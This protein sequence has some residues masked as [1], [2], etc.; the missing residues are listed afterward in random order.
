V[1]PDHETNQLPTTCTDC[2]TQNTWAPSTF[3]H[4][5]FYPLLGAHATIANQCTQCHING[6][7]STTPNT[8][9]GCHQADYNNTTNP[10]HQTQQFPSDCTDCHSQDAWIPSS[11]N[12]SSFYPLTGAHALI[13]D[14]CIMCHTSGNYNTTPS[15]CVGCHQ[16]DF[17]TASNP[18]HISL[19]FATDCVS[20]H[21][22]A[23]GWQPASMP[24]H[25]DFYILDGAHLVIANQ[26]NDCHNGNYNNTPN[27]CYGCHTQDY[28][29][30]VDPSH[31]IQQYP[32]D[33]TICHNQ[34]AWI[35]SSFDH[36]DFYA[37]T[38]AHSSISNDC[39]ACHNGNYS[40]TPNTCSGCH[41]PDFNSASNPNH[42]TLGLSNVC[43]TCHTTDPDWEPALFPQHNSVWVI[44]GAHSSLDCVDCH[45]GNYNNTPTTCFGCHQSDYNATNNP[46]H[47]SAQFPTNC[48]MCHNQNAWDPSTFDHDNQYFP[49][50]SG[51]HD[52]EW[53]VCA[54]CHF[55]PNNY[56]QFTCIDCHEHDNQS[57]V[58]ADHNGV[59]GFQYNSNACYSCHPDGE[60]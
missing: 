58:T 14:D 33:C 39:I 59:N 15:T 35:P 54:D 49:I 7:Y 53:D 42:N 20:C 18:N 44:T 37:L 55:N 45:N 36:S 56:S 16:T 38:G 10:D 50:Y 47:Q 21:T 48:T 60:E 12:H 25:D 26:C 27:T 1:D 11:F 51:K 23:V 2:H 19:N 52:N 24:N 30:T 17:N 5:S 8:C 6:N 9:V 41:M 46:D 43:T 4:S 31:L 32:T 13:A 22:T 40:S 28:N 57:E 29:T 34:A 3:D